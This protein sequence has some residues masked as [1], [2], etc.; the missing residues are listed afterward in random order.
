[1]AVRS[2]RV[3]SILCLAAIAGLVLFGVMAWRSVTVDRAEPDDAL[4]RFNDVRSQF[5]GSEPFLRV[6]ADGRVTRVSEPLG[7]GV[8]PKHF[9]VLAYRAPERRLVRASMAFWFLKA[10]GPAV[11]YA[12]RGTGLDLDRLR[13]SPQDLS[14]Y[15]AGLVLDQT[16]ADGSRLLVWTE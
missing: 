7:E 14:R 10:K 3:L 15:G 16:A 12:L 9:R 13:I 1:M 5:A 8:A 2:L 4:A 6:E 11:K